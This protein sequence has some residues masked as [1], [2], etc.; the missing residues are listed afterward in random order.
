MKKIVLT[1][2]FVA[3]S[4][5]TY[6]QNVAYNMPKSITTKQATFTFSKVKATKSSYFINYKVKNT[7]DGILIINRENTNLLQNKGE[8]KPTKGEYIIKSGKSKTIY[9]QFRVK[10]PV[11]GAADRFYVQMNGVRYA[12][13]PGKPV[14]T[15][16]LVVTEKAVQSLGDFT[17]KI[18]EYNVYP[19]RSYV[20]VK[21]TYNGK[22]NTLGK[23]D[24]TKVKVNGGKPTIT[25]KGDIIFS[26]KSYTFSINVAPNGSELNIDWKN[27]ISVLNLEEIK[28]KKI[29]IKST[30]FKEEVKE[31][32]ESQNNSEVSVSTTEETTKPCELSYSDFSTLKKDIEKEMNAGGKPVEMAHEYLLKKC[33]NTQQVVEL[34][35]VFNLD[36]S[37]L[38]FAK[39]AYQFT[40]DKAKYHTA[41][42]KLSYVKN[43]EI[44]ENFLGQQKK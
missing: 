29:D 10:A 5:A 32:N 19:K 2:F 17:F 8:L 21:C 37:R 3:L 20:Q 34:M 43:K 28:I 1:L 12:K 38:E 13:F 11:K 24:L 9:N 6:A 27:A 26:G 39:M 30:T 33:I 22:Q 18:I 36:G 23:I 15:E 16:K 25:K 31:E 7:D 41:V 14:K 4:S 42:G 35:G 40:S 44:L